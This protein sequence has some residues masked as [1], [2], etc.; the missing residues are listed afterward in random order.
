MTTISDRLRQF[1]DDEMTFPGNP[2][3]VCG[4][5]LVALADQMTRVRSMVTE[6]ALHASFRDALDVLTFPSQ[7]KQDEFAQFVAPFGW[8]VEGLRKLPNRPEPLVRA[9]EY[10]V[11]AMVVSFAVNLFDAEQQRLLPRGEN[12]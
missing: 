2:D 5:L 6:E 7:A 10:R 3:V 12:K 9:F 11:A 1:V 4:E 8:I